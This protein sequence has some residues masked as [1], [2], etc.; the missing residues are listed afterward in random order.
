V[1]PELRAAQLRLFR[2]VA[3]ELTAKCQFPSAPAL[4]QP[5]RLRQVQAAAAQARYCTGSEGPGEAWIGSGDMH[6]S[7]LENFAGFQ[8]ASSVRRPRIKRQASLISA[9]IEP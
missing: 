6:R 7:T 9:I 1:V 8:R 3:H 2:P 4:E 5:Q